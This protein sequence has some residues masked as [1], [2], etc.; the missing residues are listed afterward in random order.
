MAKADK[1]TLTK[2]SSGSGGFLAKALKAM[3]NPLASIAT[4]DLK[5]DSG[6]AV[7][8]G[9]YTLNLIFNGSIFGG[10]P[11][12]KIIGLSGQPATGKSFFSAYIGESFLR[13]NDTNLLF[14]F[15]SESA[16]TTK[17]IQARFT[18]NCD[19]VVHV[20]VATVEEFNRQVNEVLDGLIVDGAEA[21]KCMFILDSLGML[22]SNS[23][24]A[25]LV[26]TD[27]KADMGRQQK[28]LK[29]TFRS[30]TMK[31]AQTHSTMIVLAHSYKEIGAMYPQDLIAGG[32]GLQYAASTILFLSKT[33]DKDKTTGERFG[34][35]VRVRAFK[36]RFVREHS[37]VHTNISF[38]QGL[39]KFGG[40][41]DLALAVGVF[42]KDGN[43]VVLPNGKSKFQSQIVDEDYTP[44]VLAAIDMAAQLIYKFGSEEPKIAVDI[45]T[46][47][48]IE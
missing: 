13:Q 27:P 17:D 30:V 1:K 23:E 26:S 15:D 32:Q 35:N 34:T 12:G 20:P 38:D 43:K 22:T 7:D 33:A 45:G 28:I 41:D 46:G 48:V 14:I 47:E 5:T 39:S 29:A 2:T 36:S 6:E 11:E 19:R 40:L 24:L 25:S 9:S 16:Y 8:T 31:L 3:N 42:Q 44:E 18:I 37:V 21:P 4:E 10:V